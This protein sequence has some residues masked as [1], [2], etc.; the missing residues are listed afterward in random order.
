MRWEPSFFG[1]DLD[2]GSSSTSRR[3]FLGDNNSNNRGIDARNMF[4]YMLD[5][6]HGMDEV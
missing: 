4:E 5:I 2:A 3:V 1:D 6:Q